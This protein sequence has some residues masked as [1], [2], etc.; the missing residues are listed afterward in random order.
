[1]KRD[2]RL[3]ALPVTGHLTAGSQHKTAFRTN[4][5][6]VMWLR[7]LNLEMEENAGNLFRYLP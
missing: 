6:S 2:L 5:T 1:M 7:K 4:L 3:G